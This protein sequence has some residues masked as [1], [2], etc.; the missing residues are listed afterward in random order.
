VIFKFLP[1]FSEAAVRTQSLL[2]F[3]LEARNDNSENFSTFNINDR[4]NDEDQQRYVAFMQ[5]IP[6][7][8]EMIASFSVQY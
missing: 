5:S 1:G 4:R 2:P 8:A 3:L 6:V 7:S